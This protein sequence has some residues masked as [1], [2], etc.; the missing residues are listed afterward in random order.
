MKV[1]Y[2]SYYNNY[3][4]TTKDP[5][6]IVFIFNGHHVRWEIFHK[7]ATLYDIFSLLKYYYKIKNF[8]IMFKNNEV[9][10]KPDNIYVKN[11]TREAG[12]D[13]HVNTKE[14]ITFRD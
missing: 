2:Y 8:Y 5:L 10:H 12:N 7:K 11:I 14:K 13:I 6:F 3:I 9:Y 4:L 1:A